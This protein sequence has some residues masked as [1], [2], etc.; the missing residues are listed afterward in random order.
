LGVRPYFVD[1]S[2]QCAILVQNQYKTR[3]RV[4]AGPNFL[5]GS[6]ASRAARSVN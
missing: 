4:R 3:G 2:E 5:L 6:L 1:Y